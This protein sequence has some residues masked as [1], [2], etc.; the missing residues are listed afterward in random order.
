MSDFPT[1]VYKSPGYHRAGGG[2]TYDFMGV[3]DEAVFGAALS[4]GWRATLGEAI[5]GVKADTILNEVKQAQEA[6]DDVSPATRDELE[7]KAKELG[8]GF[9]SRTSDE[10]LAQRIAERV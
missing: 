9:N 2:A 4:D 5:A 8:I 6:V 3:D 1:I 7:Q 10:V